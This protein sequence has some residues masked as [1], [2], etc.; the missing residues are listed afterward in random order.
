MLL[1]FLVVAVLGWLAT[2]MGNVPEEKMVK[3]RKYFFSFY[4]LFLIVQ[5]SLHL[6]EDKGIGAM[7]INIPLGIVIAWAAMSGKM[8]PPTKKT[9]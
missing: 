3:I 6:W 8:N 9:S 2:K 7:A 4:G 5:G 1:V